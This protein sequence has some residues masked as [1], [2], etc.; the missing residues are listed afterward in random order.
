MLARVGRA[1]RPGR[2]SFLR[3]GRRR[4]VEPRRQYAGCARVQLYT[5]ALTSG[6]ASVTASE[7]T[8][9]SKRTKSAD[10]SSAAP[11]VGRL[12]VLPLA[13]QR[14]LRRRDGADRVGPRRRLGLASYVRAGLLSWQFNHIGKQILELVK[15]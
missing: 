12:L 4:R 14:D 13:A 3:L 1:R 8:P 9:D 10:V 11:V 5:S 7:T 15:R 6:R 2:D